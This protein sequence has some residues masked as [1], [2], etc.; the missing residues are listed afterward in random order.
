MQAYMAK[1]G[2]PFQE[3][4]VAISAVAFQPG[5]TSHYL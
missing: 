4:T 3:T 1:H 2:M 5:R